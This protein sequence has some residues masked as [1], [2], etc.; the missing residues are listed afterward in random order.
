ME[1]ALH[2]PVYYQTH[3]FP[4]AC[5]DRLHNCKG[6]VLDEQQRAKAVRESPGWQFFIGDPDSIKD[7]VAR[8]AD[9]LDRHNAE[10][11]HNP[12]DINRLHWLD[13]RWQHF[14]PVRGP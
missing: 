1:F 14:N 11:P 9:Y 7:Y 12:I 8:Y 3:P 6:N 5:E 2:G 10:N 4:C 13:P